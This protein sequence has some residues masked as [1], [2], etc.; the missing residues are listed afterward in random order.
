MYILFENAVG[1]LVAKR[2]GVGVKRMVIEVILP[3][4][5]LAA[6]YT[7]NV[8]LFYRLFMPTDEE[9]REFWHHEDGGPW[10]RLLGPLN[11][12]PYWRKVPMGFWGDEAA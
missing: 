5:L 12:V 11:E 10:A 3:H 4:E 7:Y 8:P 6:V 2:G 1:I 9:L